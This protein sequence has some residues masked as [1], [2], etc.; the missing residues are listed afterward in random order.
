MTVGAAPPSTH[1]RGR[2]RPTVAT[3]DLDAVRHNVSLIRPAGAALMAVVK[4]DGYGHG[5]SEVARA[6]LEAGAAWLGVALVEEGIRLR[7][8]GIDAPV[9]VLAEFPPGSEADALAA[10]LT[11]T[12]YSPEAI[13]AIAGA[14]GSA[15]PIGPVGVHIKVDTGMHRVGAAPG[16]AAG[17]VRAAVAAGLSVDGLWTH[18]AVADEGG[19]PYTDRQLER[20]R[21]AAAEVAADG[22][23]PILHAAN[24]AALLSR[25]DAHFDLVRAGIAVYGLSPDPALDS[26]AAGLRPAMS[27]TSRVSFVKRLAGAEAL[28]YGLRYRLD[29]RANVATVPVGYGDGYA[30]ALSGRASV[31]IRGRRRP[32]AGTISMDQ[33]LVDVGDD[34]V[35]A[36]EEVVLL[37]RQG[38]EEITAGELARLAGTIAY[39][40]VCA[41]GRRVPREYVHV[42]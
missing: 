12:V 30:R 4:A 28:G 15:H 9:L 19:D 40:V 1:A 27:W 24:S 29:R 21:A 37:G 32:V 35:R 23:R 34:P 13:R 16:D 20:F 26:G 17:L 10:G 8:S 33:L 6:A 25:P 39:E 7:D 3:I 41:V 5:A 36:G 31:L 42:G 14:R 18:L 38:D 22:V 11:P 2:F